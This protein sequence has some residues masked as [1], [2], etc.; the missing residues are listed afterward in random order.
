MNRDKYRNFLLQRMQYATQGSGGDEVICKCMYCPDNGD[1]Y[2]MNIS[3]PRTEKEL[4][5]FNCWKCHTSGVVTYK[6][7][8]EWGVYDADIATELSVHNQTA[9]NSSP[10]GLSELSNFNRH[11]I[12][13]NTPCPQNDIKL[14]YINDRL[15]INLEYEAADCMNIVLNVGE[16]LFNNH[17]Q[18]T[19]RDPRA[20]QSLCDNFVGFLSAD[21]CY[22]NLRRIVSEGMLHKSVDK[23]Y[24]NYNIFG[25]K[26]NT[27]KFYSIP[28]Y[29]NTDSMIEVHIA[30]GPF[31]ILSVR[32]NLIGSELNP[33]P[34]KCYFAV[35]GNEYLTLLRYLMTNM[36]LLYLE[37]HFYLD[38][39]EAGSYTWKTIMEF[40]KPLYL[41]PIYIHKNAIGKDMGV[42][43]NQIEE[44][45]E[46]IR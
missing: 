32:T 4:S 35:A 18:N 26:D 12:V 40:L 46:R 44:V 43:M 42:P 10:I 5:F 16:L 19:T 15:G 24:I 39:D 14:K 11:L 31:D 30:E 25:K 41:I 3:I 45:V 17:I 23:K 21:N 37:F 36:K 27:M 2:H 6:K 7:L 38:N 22:V 29:I 28:S 34:N 20:F 9:F 33:N 1:H 13:R 8:L